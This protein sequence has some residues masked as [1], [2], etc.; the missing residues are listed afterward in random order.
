M[1]LLD[2]TLFLKAI[3]E[4]F[5]DER[6]RDGFKVESIVMVVVSVVYLILPSTQIIK[7]LYEEKFNLEA[8]TYEEVKD[9][10][11][12]SYKN[13]NPVYRRIKIKNIEDSVDE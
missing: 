2:F 10:F 1:K 5:F 9:T 4:L 13:Q 7:F 6:I 8:R 11:N 3:G 12:D